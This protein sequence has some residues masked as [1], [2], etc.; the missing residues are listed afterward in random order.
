MIV[1]SKQL[2]PGAE[3]CGCHLCL[4]H[5]SRQ[6]R[7]LLKSRWECRRGEIGAT[8]SRDRWLASLPQN[9]GRLGAVVVGAKRRERTGRRLRMGLCA[10]RK[11]MHLLSAFQNIFF[12]GSSWG[13]LVHYMRNWPFPHDLLLLSDALLGQRRREK[14][15]EERWNSIQGEGVRGQAGQG[16]DQPWT[17]CN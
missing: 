14:C 4:P 6:L 16:F 17:S 11:Q 10:V 8:I 13:W 9:C 12:F 3:Q 5:L 1:R 15:E 7:S 2:L